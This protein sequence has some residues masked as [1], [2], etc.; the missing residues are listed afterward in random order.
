MSRELKAPTI[1]EPNAFY[2]RLISMRYT[3]RKSFESMSPASKL[4]LT[5]YER[6]KR[7]HETRQAQA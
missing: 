3:D 1:F 2:E 5:Q 7:E 4:A 6:L